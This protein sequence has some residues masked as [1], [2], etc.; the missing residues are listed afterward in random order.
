MRHFRVAH[1]HVCVTEYG[2]LHI[3]CECFA[4][5]GCVSYVSCICGVCICVLYMDIHIAYVDCVHF[6][7]VCFAHGVGV[8]RKSH[9]TDVL[10]FK[11]LYRPHL[12][13]MSS[14]VV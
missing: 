5:V 4:Y 13:H 9:P 12:V 1:T 11:T 8:V 6:K 10:H 3:L 14:T 2:C 7:C